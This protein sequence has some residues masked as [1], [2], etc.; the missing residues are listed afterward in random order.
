MLVTSIV[1]GFAGC[2][3]DEIALFVGEV[4]SLPVRSLSCDAGNTGFCET[5]CVAS[6][7]L[8]IYIVCCWIEECYGRDVYPRYKGSV[9]GV[10]GHSI[11]RL[12]RLVR[13]VGVGKAIWG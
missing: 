12:N 8:D 3:G 7:G 13:V 2:T 1:Q 5:N 9:A 6:Y 4:D 10:V 11:D